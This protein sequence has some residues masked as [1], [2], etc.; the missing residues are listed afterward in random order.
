MAGVGGFVIVHPERQVEFVV[1]EVIR[2]LAVAQPGQFEL[3]RAGAV[4]EVDDDE[5]T[6]LRIDAPDLLQVERIGVEFKA[7]FEIEN[8]EIVV[9]HLE[10]HR[11]TS[12]VGKKHFHILYTAGENILC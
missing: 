5:R 6:V 12:C 8:V 11:Q 7:F 2:F 1:A 4:F 3:V 10:F 9:D